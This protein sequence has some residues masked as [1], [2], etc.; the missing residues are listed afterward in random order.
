MRQI[1]RIPTGYYLNK[2]IYE[3]HLAQQA[4]E[5][6]KLVSVVEE[7][8]KATGMVTLEFERDSL[9]ESI[10]HWKKN[11]SAE[12]IDEVHI[13]SEH[14]A[15]CKEYTKEVGIGLVSCGECPVAKKT[16]QSTCFGSPYYKAHHAWNV[17]RSAKDSQSAAEAREDF[18]AAA[19]EEVAFLESLRTG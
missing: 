2:E 8:A 14:C 6:W 4:E 9:E 10:K 17:W 3:N 16:R 13:G 1:I 11:A 12:N 5:G 15:L 19:Q 7:T 18:V